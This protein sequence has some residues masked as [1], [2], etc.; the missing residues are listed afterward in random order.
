MRGRVFKIGI[1]GSYGGLNLGDEAI[2]QCIITQLRKS[3][4]FELIVF[5]RNAHDT[6]KRHPGVQAVDIRKM[7][8]RDIRSII[9]TLDL[10]ILG[11]GGILYDADAKL[12][13]K[14]VHIALENKIPVMLYAIGVGPL[15]NPSVQVAVRDIL[16]EVDL[17]TVREQNSQ[18]LLENLGVYKTI[19]VTADPALLLESEPLDKKIIDRYIPDKQKKLIG[20]SVR[21]PNVAAPDIDEGKYHALIAD[22]AD[23]MVDRLNAEVLF[24]PMEPDVKDLQQSHAVIS[25]MLKP[26]RAAVLKGNFTS[27]QILNIIGKLDF[28]LGMRLHFLIFSA[29]QKIP[30]V[31][32]PYASKVQGFLYD[33][34]IQMPPIQLVNAGRLIAHI[35]YFWDLREQLKL[36]ISEKLS[37]LKER[38]AKTNRLLIDL[39]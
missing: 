22:A 2:L 5:S 3:I 37:G 1:S 33:L 8:I 36:K 19:T 17:I 21:E 28:C 38:S 30:F 31:A 13:L 6:L 24:I 9:S 12:Y 16:N 39:L 35:D 20:I 18:R 25:K 4:S 29:L 27:G 34:D 11:G 23:F 7:Y 10:F 26:Q 32:L 15:N 14:E